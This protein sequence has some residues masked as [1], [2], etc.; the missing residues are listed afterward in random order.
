MVMLN[1]LSFIIN[2][3][4]IVRYVLAHQPIALPSDLKDAYTNVFF[5]IT[6]KQFLSFTSLG[7]KIQ[8]E[9]TLIIK[10]GAPS[11]Y[12]YFLLE[13]HVRIS[14]EGGPSLLLQKNQFIGEMSFLTGGVYSKDVTAD[15]SVTLLAWKHEDLNKLKIKNNP[16]YTSIQAII[17]R[18]LAKKLDQ[19]QSNIIPDEA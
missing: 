3:V 13:G 1:G 16:L 2:A 15:G 12:L 7:E 14:S 19:F 4:Q 8:T 9:N 5:L 6:P 17:G 18:D 10:Q 11:E